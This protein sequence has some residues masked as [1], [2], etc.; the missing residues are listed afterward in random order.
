MRGS[1]SQHEGIMTKESLLEAKALWEKRKSAGDKQ[2]EYK[3][4]KIEKSLA[5]LPE[6]EKSKK[7][8]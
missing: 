8:K 6:T 4:A 2:A 5:A 3:L 1:D 7:S